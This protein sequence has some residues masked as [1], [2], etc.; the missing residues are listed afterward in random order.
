MALAL[1]NKVTNGKFEAMSAGTQ[2][3][4]TKPLADFSPAADNVIACLLE[5]EINVSKC[6][7]QQLTAEMVASADKV[8]FISSE[9]DPVP[10]YLT[11]NSKVINWRVDDPK[12]TDIKFHRMVRD[13]IKNKIQTL[14]LN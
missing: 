9:S 6:V 2:S 8:I 14:N 11:N 7:P 4:P 1:F 10:D 3:A 13:E 12:G 5:E